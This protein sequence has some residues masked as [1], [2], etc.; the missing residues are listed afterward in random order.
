MKPHALELIALRFLACFY[1]PIWLTEDAINR[2]LFSFPFFL[3]MAFQQ[4]LVSK[5]S[6]LNK[7][8][9]ML[10]VDLCPAPT[11]RF[12]RAWFVATGEASESRGTLMSQSDIDIVMDTISAPDVYPPD[13]YLDNQYL[14]PDFVNWILVDVIAPVE[15][16]GLLVCALSGKQFAEKCKKLNKQINVIEIPSWLCECR[17]TVARAQKHE[18]LV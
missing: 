16:A 5:F 15:G 13:E 10:I 8:D 17:L 11:A 3:R 14:C 4:R 9:G 7:Q 12:S 6:V 2:L 1:I 18:Q